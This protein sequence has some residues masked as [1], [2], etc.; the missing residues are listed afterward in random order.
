MDLI[1]NLSTTTPPVLTVTPDD[2]GVSSSNSGIT[3]TWKRDTTGANFQFT[4]NS[5]TGLLPPTFTNPTYDSGKNTFTVTDNHPN[6]SPAPGDYPYTLTV[7]AGTT[8]CTA[9]GNPT[10]RNR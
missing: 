7:M 1:V 3:L 8:P 10:I 6:T 5:V 2:E 9:G 4:A